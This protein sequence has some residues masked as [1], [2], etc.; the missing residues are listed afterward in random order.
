MAA[1]Y[2]R[3][4]QRYYRKDGKPT[5][6]LPGIRVALR[7]LRENYGPTRAVDF[8]PLA[9]QALL[10][11]MITAGQ[12]R[13]YVNDNLGR[14]KRVFKWAAGQELI[15]VAVYQALAIVP[16]FKAGRT[17]A[18]EPAP[19]MPVDEAVVDATLP[20]LSPVVADMIRL[21]RLTGCR[22]GEVCGLRPM[23]VDRGVDV[24]VFRPSVHKTQHLGRERRIAIAPRA[25]AI[26]APY[27]LRAADAFC[28]SP[29]ESEAHRKLE[30]RANRK[31]PVQPSQRDRS[32]RKPERSAGLR[33]TTDSYRRAIARGCELAFAMPVDLRKRPKDE[34]LEQREA[35]LQRA[36]EWREANTWHP[37]QLRHSAA[38]EIR[39]RFGLEAAQVALGHSSADV[40][41]VYAERDATL[42]ARVAREVG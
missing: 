27:L 15:E 6:A 10:D 21:Q 33:Y 40:T 36:R 32:K 16:G 5:G 22:P 18:R 3:F 28:F 8:G 14:L 2:W 20:H 42:A 35:R 37:N 30:L 26:L 23:D 9:M 12:S 34:T 13:T 17:E 31:T 4:A 24:W 11:R 19:I 1:A 29:A 39:K 38:T 25:Q 7:L 41:Q